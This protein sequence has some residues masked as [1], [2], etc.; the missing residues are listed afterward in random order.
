MVR[1]EGWLGREGSEGTG[2][3]RGLEAGEGEDGERAEAKREAGSA[4]GCMP[5]AD[6]AVAG[7]G[8]GQGS[9]ERTAEIMPSSRASSSTASSKAVRSDC[10]SV[11]AS[12]LPSVLS[13]PTHYMGA[14]GAPQSSC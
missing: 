10:D 14:P 6:A 4:A 1:S 13:A 7:R 12:S 8:T 2:A 11:A 9:R 3:R 5:C